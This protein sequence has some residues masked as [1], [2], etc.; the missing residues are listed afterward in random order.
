MSKVLNILDRLGRDAELQH[1]SSE[2]LTQA[3]LDMDLDQV[4]LTAMV[5]SDAA[6]LASILGAPS[7]VVC[8]LFPG[9][10]EEETPDEDEEEDA[11]DREEDPNVSIRRA[12][13]H[14]NSC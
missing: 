10:E 5:N 9:K 6:A 12:A 8:G 13:V 14:A 7:N 3:L 4:T 11:P 1:V 2:A